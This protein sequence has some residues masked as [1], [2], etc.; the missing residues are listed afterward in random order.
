MAGKDVDIAELNR[1]LRESNEALEVEKQKV[2]S[3]EIDLDAE[4]LKSESAEEA[5]KVTQA[6]LDVAQDNYAEV[7]ATVEP[8]V[9][10]LEWL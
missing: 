8:F 5:R 1:R 7:Q 10:N 4:K 3:L 2:E 6:Y 9:N